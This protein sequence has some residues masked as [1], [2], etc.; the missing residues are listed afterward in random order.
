[1]PFIDLELQS[2]KWLFSMFDHDSKISFH[3][4]ENDHK[5]DFGSVR[6]VGHEANFHERLFLEASFSI[7]DPQSGNVN[8]EFPQ[9]ALDVLLAGS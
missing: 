5:M 6:I 2:V 1:M 4:H 8:T 7:K 3:V 9:R